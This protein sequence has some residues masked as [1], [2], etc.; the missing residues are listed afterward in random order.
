MESSSWCYPF[1]DH[2]IMKDRMRTLSP[3]LDGLD[4]AVL[5]VGYGS[6]SGQVAMRFSYSFGF[7]YGSRSRLVGDEEENGRSIFKQLT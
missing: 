7:G 2:N 6:I 5:V 3:A 1:N 4:H